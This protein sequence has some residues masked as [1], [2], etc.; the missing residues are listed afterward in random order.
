MEQ[1]QTIRR[2]L[3][4][5]PE[6]DK[7]LPKTIAYI[8]DCLKE[9]NCIVFQPI[10]SAVCA[11]FDF[12][13]ESTLAYRSDMDALAIQEKNHVDYCSLHD[14]QMHAC[15]H[16]GHMAM[17]LA[18]ASC[19]NQRKTCKHNVLLIFQPAEETLGGAKEI[20]ETGLFSKYRVA[21]LFAIHLMPELKKG[22]IASKS[23][24]LMAKSSEITI[25]ITGLSAH[26]VKYR[27]GKDALYTACRFIDKIYTVSNAYRQ[28]EHLLKFG[29]LNSG[30]ICNAVSDYSILKGSLRVF[31]D[32][33]FHYF[34]QQMIKLCEQLQH[35][36][37][38]ILQLHLSEG[39]P[40]LY[41]DDD[42]FKRCQMLLP[43]MTVL[44]NPNLLAED[45][46]YYGKA[47][48][49]MFLFL[50]IG[51]TPPLHSDTFDFDD[52][53]LINGVNAY[54]KLLDLKVSY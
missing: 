3:H 53:C 16:D 18:F 54:I 8:T 25:E 37:G 2:R 46:A 44:P 34:K 36:S 39:Y 21:A 6:L 38:C 22:S 20:V 14:G 10:P 48:K 28:S 1:I 27:E 33:T 50:G 31:D 19:L 11:Y 47:V 52:S 15:G 42:L 12:K 41:N 30:R 5:I 35:E 51:N 9:M 13:Q 43:N 4:Q 7:H 24:Y 17:L 29:F 26:I 32:H 23:G 40:A 49:S 45:F